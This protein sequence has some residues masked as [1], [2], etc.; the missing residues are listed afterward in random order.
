MAAPT[1]AATPV[2]VPS[3]TPAAAGAGDAAAANADLPPGWTAVW[4]NSKVRECNLRELVGASVRE[5]LDLRHRI[6]SH[7]PYALCSR[8]PPLSADFGTQ[9]NGRIVDSAFTVAFNPRYD[10]LLAAARDATNCGV[11][12]AGIDVRLCDIGAAIQVGGG[13]GVGG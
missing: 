5:V 6:L 12:E 3:G 13:V 11:R 8:P 10:P 7:Q 1:V 2:A 9:I 4:S